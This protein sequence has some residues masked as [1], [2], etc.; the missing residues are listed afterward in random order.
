MEPDDGSVERI[1]ERKKWH[2]RAFSEIVHHVE[3]HS[4]GTRWSAICFK[5]K[6]VRLSCQ[7]QKVVSRKR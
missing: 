1:T 2:S 5:V 4:Q 3:P 7:F 6:P